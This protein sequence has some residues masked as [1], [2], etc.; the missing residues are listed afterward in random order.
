MTHRFPSV[1]LLLLA[2]ILTP[3]VTLAQANLSKVLGMLPPDAEIAFAADLGALRNPKSLL[4]VVPRGELEKAVSQAQKQGA[5]TTPARSATEAGLRV[6][7]GKVGTIRF[8]SIAVGVMTAGDPA[9]GIRIQRDY[10]AI[11]GN[12]K[13]AEVA[14]ALKAMKVIP[15]SAGKNGLFPSAK[16]A[17]LFINSPTDN[18]LLISS[19]AGWLSAAQGLLKQ[20]NGLTANNTDFDSAVESMGGMS[21]DFLLFLDGS[22]PSRLAGNSAMTR[23]MLGPFTKT[24]GTVMSIHSAAVPTVE[25]RSAFENAET[26]GFAQSFLESAISLGRAQAT[27]ELSQTVDAADKRYLQDTIDLIDK[28]KP[29]VSGKSMVLRVPIEKRPDTEMVAGM[30]TEAFRSALQGNLQ[31]PISLP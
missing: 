31:L 24:K 8:N 2:V 14:T 6:A 16:G 20:Q 12:F 23:M 11:G 13:G 4:S 29:E 18:V 28:M 15:W 17:Q 25:L 10:V 22:I 9:D 19:D 27:D 5:A 21:P 3:C 26:A 30:V 7:F 1:F